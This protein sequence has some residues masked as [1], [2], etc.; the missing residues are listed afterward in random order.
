[1]YNSVSVCL[2]FC[3]YAPMYVHVLVCLSVS[4]SFVCLFF[5]LSVCTSFLCLSVR[6]SVSLSVRPSVCPSVCLSVPLSACLSLCLSACLPCP[7]DISCIPVAITGGYLIVM[8]LDYFVENM[9]AFI[10]A[11]NLL[12]RR[13]KPTFPNCPA[14]W[15]ML[16]T[17]PVLA[18][19]G[20]IIQGKFT[21]KGDRHSRSKQSDT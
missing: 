20:L 1:M 19:V 4:L 7:L 6:L 11:W 16:C 9:Q 13:T 8:G 15:V 2:S 18:L 14:T 17:W 5:C 10:Y 12:D 3:M 21:G